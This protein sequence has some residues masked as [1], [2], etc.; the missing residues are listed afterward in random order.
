MF[1]PKTRI[2][3]LDPFMRTFWAVLLIGMLPA[4]LFITGNAIVFA[5]R[6]G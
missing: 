6:R 5:R 2:E 4:G 3:G 1:A